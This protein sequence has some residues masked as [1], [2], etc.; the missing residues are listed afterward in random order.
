MPILHQSSLLTSANV[1]TNMEGEGLEIIRIVAFRELLTTLNEF[2]S[3]NPR[4][5]VGY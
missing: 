2:K 5:I 1:N 3:T 4:R